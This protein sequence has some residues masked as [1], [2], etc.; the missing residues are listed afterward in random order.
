[1]AEKALDAGIE[2]FVDRIELDEFLARVEFAG[3]AS[4]GLETVLREICQG[5]AA[6]RS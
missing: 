2:R 4:P 6:S 1:L 3:L 5:C